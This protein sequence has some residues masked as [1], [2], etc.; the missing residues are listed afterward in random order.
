MFEYPKCAFT[1]TVTDPITSKAI[2]RL[3]ENAR[4]RNHAV[5]LSRRVTMACAIVVGFDIWTSNPFRLLAG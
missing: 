1:D 4:P 5:D 3:T 2:R